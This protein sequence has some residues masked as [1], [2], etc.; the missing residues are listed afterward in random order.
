MPDHRDR[1]HELEVARVIKELER[2]VAAR[3][4]AWPIG[5]VGP[6]HSGRRLGALLVTRG[7]M[8]QDELE[9]AL[10]GSRGPVSAY[11]APTPNAA[12]HI[13][14]T[15]ED[16]PL[17]L[18]AL[19][20]IGALFLGLTSVPRWLTIPPASGSVPVLVHAGVPAPE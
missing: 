2:I 20:C 14:S 7:F 5:V 17:P 13:V 4:T 11:R 6:R 19:L 8:M 16:I 9:R 18:V 3:G 10:S 1:C 15:T 12:R